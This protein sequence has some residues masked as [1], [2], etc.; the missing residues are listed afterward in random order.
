MYWSDRHF[1]EVLEKNSLNGYIS[2]LYDY[3]GQI[4]WFTIGEDKDNVTILIHGAPGS[5]NSLRSF[6]LDDRLLEYTQFIAVDR[7]GYGKSDFSTLNSVVLQALR[8]SYIIDNIPEYKKIYILASSYGGA[9]AA[10]LAMICPDRIEGMILASPSL[11]PGAEQKIRV[12]NLLANNIFQ[13]YA[14]NALTT[15]SLE[16]L[17]HADFLREL[18]DDW[19]MIKSQ[20]ILLHGLRDALIYAENSIHSYDLMVNADVELVLFEDLSHDIIWDS[21][22]IVKR[23]LIEMIED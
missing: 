22:H 23:K 20:T 10:R 19:H 1:F 6:F 12:S 8:I 11:K 13:K 5:A 21:T 9:V 15:A 7:P 2:Y 18:Q 4:R 14:T 16:K 3:W 17:Y